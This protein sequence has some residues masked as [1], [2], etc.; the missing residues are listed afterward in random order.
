MFFFNVAMGYWQPQL[1]HTRCRHNVKGSENI[2][3]Y[4]VII[5]LRFVCRCATILT[6]ANTSPMSDECTLYP[7]SLHVSR[8]CSGLC[9]S[10]C[11]LLHGASRRL[12]EEWRLQYAARELRPAHLL[13][14]LDPTPGGRATVEGGVGQTRCQKERAHQDHQGHQ[15]DSLAACGG[16]EAPARSHQGQYQVPAVAQQAQREQAAGKHTDR[17]PEHGERRIEL[18]DE[19][20]RDQR[21]AVPTAGKEVEGQMHRDGQTQP[22]HAHLEPAHP[23]TY[24]E[25]GAKRQQQTVGDDR[26]VNESD[27]GKD[28]IGVGELEADQGADD[29]GENRKEIGCHKHLLRYAHMCIQIG[30]QSHDEECLLR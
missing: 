25:I 22:G 10:R 5:L 9:V 17:Q 4:M 12:R 6:V 21:I 20:H 23:L 13:G 2:V 24:Q 19:R 3:K 7:L 11:P 26:A 18:P 1:Y 8:C 15:P 16:D 29:Q 28:L 14:A 27:Q 30:S